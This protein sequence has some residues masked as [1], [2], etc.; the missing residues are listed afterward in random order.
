MIAAPPERVYRALVDPEALVV[1]LPPTGMSGRFEHADIRA[2]G[3]YRMV[4]TYEDADTPGKTGTG[5]DVVDVRIMELAPDLR[6]VQAVDFDAH[7]PSFDGTMIMTWLLS[8]IAGGTRVDL[9]AEN[10]P[11]GIS[12]QDHAA[13]MGSSL[14]NL[15]AFVET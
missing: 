12:P 14:A 5:T 4:L 7:D 3:R 10:V 9:S 6:V 8:P 1:W 13:G 15:A 2:G 11:D